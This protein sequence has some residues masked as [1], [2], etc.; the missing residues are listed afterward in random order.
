MDG[1]AL[2]DRRIAALGDWR[3][4]ALATVRR[5]IHQ[6]DP[7][8]TEESKWATPTNVTGVPVW[9]HGGMVCTCEV[10]TDRVKVTFAHGALI[11][12]PHCLFNA[13]LNGSSRRAIDLKKG[14]ELR[15]D[16]FRELV[17]A[18]VEANLR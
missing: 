9:S 5:L 4:E 1:T 8:I 2:I 6:A 12:D 17:R 14:D 15:P 16:A 7:S 18:A 3:G 11:P 10:Y 13:S